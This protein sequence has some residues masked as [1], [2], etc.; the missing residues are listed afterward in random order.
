MSIFHQQFTNSEIVAA[1][2]VTNFQLQNWLKRGQIIGHGV[3]GGG[4][5]GKHR[6]FSFFNLMQ[7]AVA[8][9]LI[10]V[11]MTDMQQ[12]THAAGC[13]AHTGDMAIGNR[14]ERI[15]GFPFKEGKTLLIAGPER[16]E[17][18][19]LLS[20]ERLGLAAAIFKHGVGAV[21]INVSAVFENTLRR[22]GFDPIEI[23][24]EAYKG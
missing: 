19:Q 17:E 1:T 13:F 18:Y 7:I 24:R 5:P 14:P 8:K 15:P 2:G 22:A 3:E 12:V 10:D 16:S 11:G 20:S 4:S 23:T 6:K 21:V 9:A